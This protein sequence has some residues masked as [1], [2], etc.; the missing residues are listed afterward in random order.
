MR[1]KHMERHRTIRFL[2]H[3]IFEKT[4]LR[5]ERQELRYAGRV[6]GGSTRLCDTRAESDGGLCTFHVSRIEAEAED[7]VEA[8]AENDAFGGLSPVEGMSP[9]EG[10]SPA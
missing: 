6:W 2:K 3:L 10:L 8:E 9:I 4:K 7:D 5:P 1:F